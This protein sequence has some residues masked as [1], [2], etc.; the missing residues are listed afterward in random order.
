MRYELTVGY[1]LVCECSNTPTLYPPHRVQ[2]QCAS[3]ECSI[4]YYNT[5]M[6][7]ITATFQALS[8]EMVQLTDVFCKGDLSEVPRILI[9]LQHREKDK[10]SLTVKWQVMM[11]K[12]RAEQAG[13]GPDAA[14]S[15]E[16]TDHERSQLRRRCG[17]RN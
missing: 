13:G 11:E 5:A 3:Q 4:E 14:E 7:R 6:T 2:Q 1:L 10:L 15:V 16:V 12:H 8:K 17:R 9:D